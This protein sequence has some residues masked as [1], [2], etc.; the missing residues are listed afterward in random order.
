M[1]DPGHELRPHHTG[2]IELAFSLDHLET[3]FQDA[4]RQG[5]DAAVRRLRV[6]RRCG[7]ARSAPDGTHVMSMF[8]QWVPD[9][10]AARARTTPSWQAYAD[11]VVGL[12]DQVAPGSASR[13][14]TAR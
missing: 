4:V 6:S 12:F 9:S 7:T 14:C 2:A 1:A 3:A 11:R 8:T 13:S 5:V 10:W